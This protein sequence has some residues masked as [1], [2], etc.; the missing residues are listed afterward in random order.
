MWGGGWPRTGKSDREAGETATRSAAHLSAPPCSAS[1]YRRGSQLS[2]IQ[3]VDFYHA[4]QHLGELSAKLFAHD[5]RGR[6]RWT[7][8]LLHK[9]D[10]GKIEALGKALRAFSAPKGTL[11]NAG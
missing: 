4:R 2:A 3:I 5:Q 8:G 1:C 10:Q 9:L 7:V 6:K 11:R